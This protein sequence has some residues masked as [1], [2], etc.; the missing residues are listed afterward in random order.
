MKVHRDGSWRQYWGSKKPEDWKALGTITRAALEVGALFLLPSGQYV[1]GN[2]GAIR[3]LDQKK[4]IEELGRLSK[5][6]SSMDQSWKRGE[7][8]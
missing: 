7:E 2:A 1:Q 8:K 5:N 4:V 6:R 3:S